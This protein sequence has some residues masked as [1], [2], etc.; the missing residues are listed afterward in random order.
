M[1]GGLA[2][3]VGAVVAGLTLRETSRQN[4]AVVE[5]QRRGQVTERFTRAGLTGARLL[6]EECVAIRRQLG[7]RCCLPCLQ[8]RRHPDR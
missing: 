1:L 7:S 8:P 6:L 5:L 4:R 2:V 3:L